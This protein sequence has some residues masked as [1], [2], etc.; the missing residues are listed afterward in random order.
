MSINQTESGKSVYCS[1]PFEQRVN[2]PHYETLRGLIRKY[3]RTHHILD[4]GCSD[5]AAT[6]PLEE[7]GYTI[8]GL[9]LDPSALSKARCNCSRASLIG[10]DLNCLPLGRLGQIDTILAAD[11]LEHL[12]EDEAI[13][14]LKRM[15]EIGGCSISIIVAMPII[16]NYSV[17]YLIEAAQAKLRGQRP[18]TG[19]LDRTH[20]ILTNT[21]GHRKIFGEADYLVNEESLTLFGTKNIAAKFLLHTAVPR[22]IHPFNEVE[23]EATMNRLTACQGIYV[24]TPNQN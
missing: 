4:L 12:N 23:R 16:S 3:S 9:D 20:F 5:L 13:R 21:D 2:Q 24:I 10:A 22:L 11:I 1:T 6:Q 14:L 7:E 18:E 15:T 19:L 17:P 8:Y